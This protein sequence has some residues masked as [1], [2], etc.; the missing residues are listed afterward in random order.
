MTIS[1][2]P[3]HRVCFEPGRTARS[4]SDS[5]CGSDKTNPNIEAVHVVCCLTHRPH[6]PLLVSHQKFDPLSINGP[7]SSNIYITEI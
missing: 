4:D 6:L 5:L 3:L 1:Y 2:L 7:C